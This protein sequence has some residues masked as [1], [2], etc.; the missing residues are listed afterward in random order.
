MPPRQCVYSRRLLEEALSARAPHGPLRLVLRALA[1]ALARVR[2]AGQLLLLN[3][4]LLLSLS[5]PLVHHHPNL[6]HPLLE[7]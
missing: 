1:L 7:A 5:A 2:G 4:R 6:I 3:H